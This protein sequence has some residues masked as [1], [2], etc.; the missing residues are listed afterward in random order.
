MQRDEQ[1]RAS[2]LPE[3][4]GRSPHEDGLKPVEGAWQAL[5]LQ[6]SAGNRS[7]SRLLARAP[8]TAE[9]LDTQQKGEKPKTETAGGAGGLVTLPDI[10][11]IPLLSIQFA[12]MSRP[13]SSRDREGGRVSVNQITFFSKVGDHS[14]KLF[15]ASNAGTRMAVVEVVAGGGSWRVKLLGA[16]VTSYSTASQEGESTES[17]SLN[18]ESIEWPTGAAPGAGSGG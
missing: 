9:A 18:F 5:A 3:E 7:L 14:M 10:G 11:A 1:A 13:G 6:R 4:L 8:D 2:P 16:I 12:P 15:Q 17:W